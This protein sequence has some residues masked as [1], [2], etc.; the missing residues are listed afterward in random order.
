MQFGGFLNIGEEKHLIDLSRMN[1]RVDNLALP[2][3]TE[4]GHGALSERNDE[5]T[6]Y[7]EL[8]D[9]EEARTGIAAAGLGMTTVEPRYAPVDMAAEP[10]AT[11]AVGM[12]SPE[13]RVDP[14]DTP[15]RLNIG[16]GMKC[17]P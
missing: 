12:N 3:I 2:G 1:W 10:A 4:V 7:V 17:C 9:H 14:V 13:H 6:G 11:G 16:T 5:K 15:T 8:T